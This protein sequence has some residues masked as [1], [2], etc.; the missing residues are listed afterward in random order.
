VG[1]GVSQKSALLDSNVD[2]QKR[3]YGYHRLDDPLMVMTDQ[4]GQ[5]L[6]CPESEFENA[7]RQFNFQKVE[8][9]ASPEPYKG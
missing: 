4:E 6:V 3:L 5:F 8:M 2:P 1:V 9:P 7:R